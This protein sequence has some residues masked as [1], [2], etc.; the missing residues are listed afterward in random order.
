MGDS[1]RYHEMR[2]NLGKAACATRA[3]SSGTGW[4][5][6]DL[7]DMADLSVVRRM[8]QT[9]EPIMANFAYPTTWKV[10]SQISD[11]LKHFLCEIKGL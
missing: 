7:S 8:S 11:A 10:M 4:I 2:W 1:R 5:G 9:G 6:A 3:V